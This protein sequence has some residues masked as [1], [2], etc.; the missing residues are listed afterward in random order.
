MENV[1]ATVCEAERG[2]QA[3]GEGTVLEA[4][5]WPPW[6]GDPTQMLRERGCVAYEA[7]GFT[8]GDPLPV[9]QEVGG[10]PAS[11]CARSCGDSVFSGR[12]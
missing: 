9:A 10:R 4:C 6:V 11:S 8:E 12:G 2:A 3:V 7:G 5:V 1:G